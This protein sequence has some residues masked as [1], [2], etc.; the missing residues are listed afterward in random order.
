[1]S[2][3]SHVYVTYIRATPEKVWSAITD[4]DLS[5]RYWGHRNVSEWTVGA[6]WEHR[7]LDAG[8]IDLVGTVLESQPPRRLVVSW[9]FPG[10]VDK[11]AKVSRVAFDIDVHK[12]DMVRLTVSHTD[13][14]SGGEMERGITQ[15]W[16]F[17]LSSLKSFLET[18]KGLL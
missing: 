3:A 15:G 7:R 1:M 5:G 17:V 13:L 9:A 10:D 11:P 4:P 8:K 12:D 6:S 16:P 14:E 2:K 18:G